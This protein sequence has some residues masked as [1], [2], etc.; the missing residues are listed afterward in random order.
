MA[1]T[2]SGS[3]AI[4]L[5]LFVISAAFLTK[6]KLS[7]F[8]LSPPPRARVYVCARACV[9]FFVVARDA[10][11]LLRRIKPRGVTERSCGAFARRDAH[12]LRLE[13][14][15]HFVP[16]FVADF[17]NIRDG[18]SANVIGCLSFDFGAD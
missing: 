18:Y 7:F 12:K 10:Q 17:P 9:C 4:S 2:G 15:H 11:E 3:L 1:I 14:Q 8:F 5:W 13:S 6:G 16:L